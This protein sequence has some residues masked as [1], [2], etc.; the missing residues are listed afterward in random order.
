MLVATAH[1]LIVM[2]CERHTHMLIA[3]TPC[4]RCNERCAV[5]DFAAVQ[6]SQGQF[7]S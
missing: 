7:C 2:L 4:L 3:A 1:V 5:F 6:G